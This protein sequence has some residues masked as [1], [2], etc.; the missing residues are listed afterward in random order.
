MSQDKVHP[1]EAGGG[2]K[3]ATLRQAKTGTFEEA[4]GSLD[5]GFGAWDTEGKL[6]YASHFFWLLKEA[7]WLLLISPL[8]IACGAVSVAL[9]ALVMWRRRDGGASGKLYNEVLPEVLIGMTQLL[10]LIF[11]VLLMVVYFIYEIPDKVPGYAEGILDMME[12]EAE[13]CDETGDYKGL[14]WAVRIGFLVAFGTWIFSCCYLF[15]KWIEPPKFVAQGYAFQTCLLEGGWIAF[16]VLKDFLWTFD[17]DGFA[18]AII[19]WAVHFIVLVVAL[20]TNS[21]ESILWDGINEEEMQRIQEVLTCGA[22]VDM[23]HLSYIFWSVSSLLWLLMENA[24]NEDLSLRY[25]A[26]I[27]VIVSAGMFLKG[28]SQAKH[29]AEALS[30]MYAKFQA[31]PPEDK[32]SS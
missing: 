11:N 8:A 13:N 2:K 20:V 4:K 5:S 14:L 1:E 24:F 10:W 29:K 28:Y 32:A 21:S 7:T 18:V 26:A 3:P 17:E 25:F 9:A 30:L 22:H 23:I 27:V 15:K 12:C 31:L 6:L 19:A 16:W